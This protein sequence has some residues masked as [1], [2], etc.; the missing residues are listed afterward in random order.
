MNLFITL[1]EDL[2]KILELCKSYEITRG[3]FLKN[4]LFYLN[5]GSI[6]LF[7]AIFTTTLF[8]SHLLHKKNNLIWNIFMAKLSKCKPAIKQQ[9]SNRLFQTHNYMIESAEAKLFNKRSIFKYNY[10][11]RYTAISFFTFAVSISVFLLIYFLFYEQI[12]ELLEFRINFLKIMN[13][14]RTY[15]VKLAYYTMENVAE[16]NSLQKN[17]PNAFLD[18]DEMMRFNIINKNLL[19]IRRIFFTEGYNLNLPSEAFQMVFAQFNSNSSFL[20]YGINAA[21]A[22]TRYES[23]YIANND[24][25]KFDNMQEYFSRILEMT[26]SFKEISKVSDDSTLLIIKEKYKKIIMYSVLMIASS[27]TISAFVLNKWF[28]KELKVLRSLNHLAKCIQE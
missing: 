25:L 26:E 23:I 21:F 13:E 4:F 20:K 7:I 1:T 6:S 17:C 15:F 11:L 5:I 16:Q 8:F 12:H 14:R 27:L 3:K 10:F 18:Q 22:F 28:A 24:S 9:F 19:D 2:L